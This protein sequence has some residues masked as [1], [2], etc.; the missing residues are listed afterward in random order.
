MS[1]KVAQMSK[2]AGRPARLSR[3]EILE[4]AMA[5][6][7]T[8]DTKNFSIRKIAQQLGTSPSNL[9][10]YFPDKQA[11]LDA[12]GEHAFTGIQ[13]VL[14]DNL[15][16]DA[17]ITQW[18]EQ[19]HAQLLGS[20]DLLFLM[21]VAGTSAQSLAVIQAI[22]ELLESLGLSRESAVLHAQSLLWTVMSF[23]LF[24]VQAGDKRVASQLRS[25]A[26]NYE[27]PELV[28]HM[29]IENLSPLWKINLER[30]IDGLRFQVANAKQ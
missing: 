28:K 8:G 25:E 29:A 20:Q 26:D 4:S 2:K 14:D 21:G 18:I 7:K 22:S 30:N 9:Y 1:T 16:W 17:Q 10:T 11:I 5:L 24:E 6:L 15:S 13:F 27:L 3:E 19:A 12:L 23:T